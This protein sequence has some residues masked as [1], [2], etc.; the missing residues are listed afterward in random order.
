LGERVKVRIA[1]LPDGTP[2]ASILTLSFNNVVTYKYGCS[3]PQYNALGATVMLMWRT[4]QD[5]MTEG[6]AE[7]DLGR[8]DYDTPGLI[9]FKNHWGAAQSI[10][11][12]YRH[13]AAPARVRANGFVVTTARRLI[14]AVPDSVFATIG[15][16]FYRH[17][18]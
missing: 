3:D 12:Y 6:A 11:R 10:I 5:A 14:T 8:S 18:A 4:I 1:S 16:L 9:A 13:P 15:G 17:A 2:I 7:L